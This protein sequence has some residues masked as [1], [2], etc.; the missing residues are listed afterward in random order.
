MKVD[1]AQTSCISAATSIVSNIIPNQWGHYGQHLEVLGNIHIH[2]QPIVFPLLRICLSPFPL[3]VPCDFVDVINSILHMAQ[4][5]NFASNGGTF[6]LR[7]WLLPLTIHRIFQKPEPHKLTQLVTMYLLFGF[8]LQ[9]SQSHFHEYITPIKY[10]FDWKTFHSSL[11]VMKKQ[12]LPCSHLLSDPQD[13]TLCTQI[14]FSLLFPFVCSPCSM[15][16][17]SSCLNTNNA[18]LTDG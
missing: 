4:L 9:W 16:F 5:Y 12:Y 1:R 7:G 6:L 17:T 11:F 18:L 15:F 2:D 13:H 14:N 10:N 8:P 3:S